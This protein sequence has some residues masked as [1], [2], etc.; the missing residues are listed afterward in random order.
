MQYIHLSTQGDL[1]RRRTLSDADL[2]DS[3]QQE[4]GTDTAARLTSPTFPRRVD[5]WPRRM[6]D[7]GGPGYAAGTLVP[8]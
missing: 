4:R 1:L 7:E 8:V 5:V 3:P 6:A 2:G